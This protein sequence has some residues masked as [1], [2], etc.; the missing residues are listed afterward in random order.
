VRGVPAAD[1]KAAIAKQLGVSTPEA[2]RAAQAPETKTVKRSSA[3]RTG[4]VKRLY[5][6]Y[7]FAPLWFD[8]D[9]VEKRRVRALTEALVNATSDAIDLDQYQLGDLVASLD[10]LKHVDHPSAEQIARADI[11]LTSVFA[12]LAEDYLAGQIT[13]A[14]VNQSWHIDP[15]EEELDSAIVRSLRDK[16]LASAFGRMRPD[17]YEYD[18]LRRTLVDYRKIASAGGWQPIPAGKALTKGDKDSPARLAALRNR[19]RLEGFNPGDSAT[20]PNIYDATLAGAVAEFQRHHAIGVDSS[21]GTETLESMNVPA[22]F[23]LAQIASNL[24]RYRWLPRSL[25]DRYIIV[26]VPAFRLEGFDGGKKTIE[27]KVIV[28]ADYEGRATP[29]FSD[30]MEMVVFR[31]YWDV[32]QSIASKEFP[33]GLPADFEMS[34]SGANAHPRQRPGPK[35][36]LGLVKFLFPNDFNIYLHDTPADNLFEKDVRAFSHG[37]IRV[38]KP[39]ELAQWVLGWDSEKVRDAMERGPDDRTVK[40]ARK[41]PVFITYQTAY[42][43]DGQ[44][45]FGNDLYHRDDEL[46]Q[47]I[48]PAAVPSAA[49]IRAI[50]ALRA[51]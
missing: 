16:D 47:V 12:A 38:E 10:S 8:D 22:T 31:P 35:N 49:A 23:R 45:W 44:L 26:N 17:D 33:N 2:K 1:V 50:E 39:A 7:Q 29:V 41:L 24:E 15:Q 20:A 25:G 11:L 37:C 42:V 48:A 34:G 27:M 18:M 43:R 4:H 3:D 19:L 32:P 21:L 5:A 51:L 30:K 46:V 6:Q 13:P 14:S 40:L 28:G 36:A 9:G